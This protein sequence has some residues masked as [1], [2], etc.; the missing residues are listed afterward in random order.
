MRLSIV[1]NTSTFTRAS[2]KAMLR[3]VL[4]EKQQNPWV[5][6]ARGMHAHFAITR[7]KDYAKITIARRHSNA[8]VTLR[9]PP[10]VGESPM[11]EA[12]AKHLAKQLRWA[13]TMLAG[14]SLSWAITMRRYC[15]GSRTR[16]CVVMRKLPL[17]GPGRGSGA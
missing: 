14:R 17:T 3:F 2:V 9:L 5:G 7:A 1:K 15:C 8:M 11:S 12:Q 4:N 10:R 16:P 6:D 13:G